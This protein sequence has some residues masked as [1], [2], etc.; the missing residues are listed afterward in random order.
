MVIST[1]VMQYNSSGIKRVMYYK[2]S[3]IDRQNTK[4]KFWNVNIRF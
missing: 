4:L 1:Y 2:T 3:N